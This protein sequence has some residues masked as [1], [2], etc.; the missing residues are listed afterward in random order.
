MLNAIIILLFV[1]MIVGSYIVAKIDN[2]FGRKIFWASAIICAAILFLTGCGNENKVSPASTPKVESETAAEKQRRIDE[3]NEKRRAADEERQR[4]QAE[5]EASKVRNLGMTAEQFKW[6]YN[7]LA[8]EY[9]VSEVAI[10]EMTFQTGAEQDVGQY[11]ITPL[12]IFQCSVDKTTGLCK[13]VWLLSQ[14]Q[15]PD[16]V[17]AT[18]VSYGLII[19]ALSPELTQDERGQLMEMLKL[20]PDKMAQLNNGYTSSIRGNVKY[21]TGKINTSTLHLIASAKDL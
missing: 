21:T 6:S 17:I 10:G 5:I 8:A 9:G 2:N 14:P 7:E 3:E 20:T 1:L 15:V 11:N 4:R 13:E 12:L 16:Q 18:L 19:A